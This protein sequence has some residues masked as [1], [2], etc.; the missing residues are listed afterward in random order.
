[1]N[2]EFFLF[3]SLKLGPIRTGTMWFWF[4]PSL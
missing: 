1:M 4:F 2:F 3:D